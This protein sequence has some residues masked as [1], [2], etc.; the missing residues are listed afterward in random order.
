MVIANSYKVLLPIYADEFD[1]S[2]MS[3]HSKWATIKRQKGTNDAKK[4]K[5]FTKLSKAILIAVKQG[6]GDVDTNPRLR[7]ALDTA[8]SYNMPRDSID[9]AIK[10]ALGKEEKEYEEV[11]YEGFGPG[12]FSLI[13]E[14]IT[15]N[16]QRTTPEIKSRIEKLGGTMGAQGS[17]VYQFEQKGM[18]TIKDDGMNP[19]ELYLIAADC[20]AEDI[21]KIGEDFVIY[22]KREDLARVRDSLTEHSIIVKSSEF[23]RTPVTYVRL[24]D[25][26]TIRKALHFIEELEELEDVQRIYANY[27]IDD[28]IGKKLI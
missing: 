17:V 20:G 14:V 24:N 2:T 11:A 1:F 15:D 3:G 7:L 25:I 10:K 12:G 16:R 9:R 13:I 19:D 18:L 4:G 5:I 21:E 8:K 22:A 28:E 6:G 26:D 27:D 23:V